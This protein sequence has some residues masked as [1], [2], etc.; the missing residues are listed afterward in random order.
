MK[1]NYRINYR[2]KPKCTLHTAILLFKKSQH[3]ITVHIGVGENSWS[4]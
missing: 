4:L 2:Q 3:K 1:D